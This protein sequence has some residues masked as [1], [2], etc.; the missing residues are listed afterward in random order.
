VSLGI[1]RRSDC[2]CCHSRNLQTVIDFGPMPLAGSFLYPKDVDGERLFPLTLARCRDC[3]LMQ[4]SEVVDP[5]TIF[6]EYSYASSTTQTLIDHFVDMAAD[7]VA[8][9][10]QNEDVVLEI[11]CNDGVLIRP[12]RQLG[13]KAVGVDPSD[14]ARRASEA[15]HWP[16][17]SGF[18]NADSAGR[19]LSQ[20]GRVKGVIANNVFAHIDD[21]DETMSSIST[22]LRAD[23]FF[24]FEVHYQGDLVNQFQFDTIYHEHLSYYSLRSLIALLGRFKFTVIDVESIPV[25]SGS[26]RVLAVPNPAHRAAS[27]NVERFLAAE[28][29]VDVENFVAG[30]EDRRFT[31]RKV[32]QDLRFA[33][34]RVV[35]YGAAGRSTILLNYCGL[36]SSFLDYVVD[37]SPL[38]HGRLIPG[39]HV[40]IEPPD[41][42][43]RRFPDYAL[44]TAWNYE[45]EIAR[46]E[47][48]FLD[49]GG[50]F[51]IPLPEVRISRGR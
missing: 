18:L 12:M 43:Q 51:I 45:R 48:R 46:K 8:L 15:E 27:E 4:L 39:V 40:P 29:D 35:G 50:R 42:F 7:I 14:V 49:G 41:T 25:H 23:G 10:V 31:L 11:G 21:I 34:R 17:I 20:Y 44:I 3:T 33:G 5:T 47:Q 32:I 38:R 6:S 22:V 30:V 2:R 36:D 16:L 28:R 37:M 24:L 26:I 1:K 9:G 19:A 13:I